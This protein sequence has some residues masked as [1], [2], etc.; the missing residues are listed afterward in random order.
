M[1]GSSISCGERWWGKSLFGEISV[2]ENDEGELSRQETQ[3]KVNGRIDL[4]EKC[5]GKGFFVKKG[6][7]GEGSEGV[8]VSGLNEEIFG[9]KQTVTSMM[10]QIKITNK[11]SRVNKEKFKN[12]QKVCGKNKKKIKK[13]RKS[14]KS[15]EEIFTSL[16]KIIKPEEC[17]L[18][19]KKTGKNQLNFPYIDYTNLPKKQFT[20]VN[21][22]FGP[23]S[24][25]KTHTL[26]NKN[27]SPRQLTQILV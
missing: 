25:H 12:L 7:K 17:I 10:K 13:L 2:L 15:H 8:C 16:E 18:S 27:P 11:E 6:G 14:L 26:L 1:D 9:L 5:F 19:D 3:K 24:I 21:L 20:S 4:D 23:N 22:A